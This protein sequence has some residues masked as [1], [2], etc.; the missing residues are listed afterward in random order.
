MEHGL[1]QANFIGIIEFASRQPWLAL[2]AIKLGRCYH[3]GHLNLTPYHQTLYRRLR[4]EWVGNRRKEGALRQEK[5]NFGEEA[6]KEN[7]KW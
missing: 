5:E 2:A 7:R 1:I 3:P 4:R 6:C